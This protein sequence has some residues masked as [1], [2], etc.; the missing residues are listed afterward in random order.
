LAPFQE[1]TG[2]WGDEEHEAY[3][4]LNINLGHPIKLTRIAIRT[5]VKHQKRGVVLVTSSIAGTNGHLGT[6]LY[7]AS[8]HGTLGFVKSL[9]KMEDLADIKVVAICPG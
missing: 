5:F 8:K 7:V 4:L 6:P 3:A 2:F 1:Q 9:A